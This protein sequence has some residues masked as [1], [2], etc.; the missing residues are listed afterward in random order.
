MS[1]GSS[2]SFSVH[3]T[4]VNGARLEII[5][6]GHAAALIANPIIGN[7]DYTESFNLASDGAK[8]WVRIN[9]R[10]AEGHLLLV[11]NPVYLNF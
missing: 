10:S 6:D 4:H 8:H 2:V 3:A 1:K 9:V 5:N 7:D 11:S